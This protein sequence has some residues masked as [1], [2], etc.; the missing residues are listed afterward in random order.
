MIMNRKDFPALTHQGYIYFDNAATSLKP[1]SVIAAIAEWYAHHT[2]PIHRGIYTKAEQATIR[3]EAVREQIAQFLGAALSTEI[4]ITKNATESINLVAAAWGYNNLKQGDEIVVTE[5]E[6]H[7]NLLPWLALARERGVVVKFMPINSKGILDSAVY[8][9]LLS[10]RTK[11]VALTMSSNVLGDSNDLAMDPSFLGKAIMAAHAVGARVLLD[12]AQWIPHRSVNVQQLA[13]D[14]LVF[15]SHKMLGPTG[16]G[17]LYASQDAMKEMTPYQYG[18]GML[19]SFDGI[20]SLWRPAPHCFEAGT[21]AIAELIGFGAALEYRQKYI[22]LDALSQ[23]EASLCA[24]LLEGLATLPRIR[25]LGLRDALMKNGHLVSFV[26]E[27]MHAHD[28][29]AYL[30]TQGICVRAG[31]HCA[32]LLHEKLGITSSVRVSF[33]GYNTAEEV[34]QLLYHLRQ[35]HDSLII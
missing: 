33:Y 14:F 24:R 6:H 30:D 31:N 34:D 3:Y 26:M 29:A 13:P 35:L 27:G 25:V 1:A 23:H 22:D 11:L 32:Q 20:N 10:P 2:A 21:P 8:K 9:Q 18:G 15:S 7:A 12:A 16:V 4:I 17:V 19:S 28:I 5:L